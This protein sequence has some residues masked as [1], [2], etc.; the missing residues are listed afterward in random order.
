[1]GVKAKRGDAVAWPSTACYA[2]EVSGPKVY[3]TLGEVVSVTRDG[4]VKKARKY[5]GVAYYNVDLR[6]VFSRYVIPA[7]R[8]DVRAMLDAYAV[9]APSGF[10]GEDEAEALDKLRKFVQRFVIVRGGGR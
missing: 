3:F 2:G 5:D 6:G 4:V 10:G 7:D 9:E 8:L 1:M